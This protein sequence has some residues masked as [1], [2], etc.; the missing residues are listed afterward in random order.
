MELSVPAQKLLAIQETSDTIADYKFDDYVPTPEITFLECI[1]IKKDVA[2]RMLASKYGMLEIF[3]HA[4]NR[5]E[6]I[7]TMKRLSRKF[8]TLSHDAYLNQF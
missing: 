5:V 2:D 7:L 3:R 4:Y 8:S 6:A 1:P